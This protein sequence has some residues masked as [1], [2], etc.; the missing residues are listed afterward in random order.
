MT[1]RYY[2]RVKVLPRIKGQPSPST[3]PD[4]ARKAEQ[5]YDNYDEDLLQ[6]NTAFQ[7]LLVNNCTAQVVLE[8]G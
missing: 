8:L 1:E 7:D 2:G 4:E 5:P 3:V 6:L